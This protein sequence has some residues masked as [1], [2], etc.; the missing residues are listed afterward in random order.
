MKKIKAIE[1]HYKNYRFRS[2]LEARWAIFFDAMGMDWEYEP[3]GF[4]LDG[5]WYLPDFRINYKGV[6][7]WYEVKPKHVIGDAKFD[8]FKRMMIEQSFDN[9]LR[10][11]NDIPVGFKLVSGDPLEF[12]SQSGSCDPGLNVCPRCGNAEKGD[13]QYASDEA[14]WSCFSCDVTTGSGAGETISGKFCAVRPHKGVILVDDRGE[15]DKHFEGVMH[16]CKKAR[17]ARFEHGERPNV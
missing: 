11:E 3:E 17:S 9:V 12:F 14:G 1:T 5:L 16:A 15:L 2:R 4:D 7:T 8:T 10:G 6:A 13:A